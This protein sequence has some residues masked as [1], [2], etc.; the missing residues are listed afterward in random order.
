MRRA[1]LAAAAALS[2][3]LMIRGSLGADPSTI[4]RI[5]VTGQ[6]APNGG[7]F[8]RFSVESLPIVAPI[9][10][11][12]QVA[13]FASVVR[14]RSSEGFF[15]STGTRISK[16]VADGDAVPGGGV[17]SGFGRHPL[18][19]LNDAGELAFAATIT[20][21]RAVEGVFVASPRG[22]RAVALAGGAAP[23]ISSGTFAN[24]DTPSINN[25][26]EVA[27]LAIVRRGR[28]SIEAI[29][30]QSGG[31]TRKVVAQGDPAPAGGTFAGFG[32][33][34][35]NGSGLIGFAAVVEGRA[36]PGG[37]FV[38]KAGAIKM[39]V[40]AGEDTPDGGI[41][42]KFSERVAVNEAGT[43]AFNA[44]LKGAPLSGA[45]YV[46]DDRVRKVVGLGEVAPGGGVFSHFGL[47]PSLSASGAVVFAASVDGGPAPVAVF[48]AGRGATSKVAAVG[49]ALPGGGSLVSFGLYPFAAASR[50][51]SI[52]FATAPDAVGAGAEGVFAIDSGLGR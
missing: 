33:P 36:V 28:E 35:L 37:V 48:L 29:Y 9:N 18:P 22:V 39:L 51:G 21:A 31:K 5:A 10:G 49:D 26:G 17:F 47:W 20:G 7:L 52:T 34:S 8:D 6:A 11:K 4:R 44:I 13:F 41:F 14:G 30:L 46:V 15:L 43:I 42:A 23:D 12:G 38:A 24:L 1:C 45:I 25:R 16:L 40:G 50:S 2:V 27:F 3:L 32:P 19:T